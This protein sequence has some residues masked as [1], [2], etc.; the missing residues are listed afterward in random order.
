MCG[1]GWAW[2]SAGRLA[3]ER[4]LGAQRARRAEARRTR[5][6]RVVVRLARISALARK[7]HG[8]LEGRRGRPRRTKAP[9]R[10]GPGAREAGCAGAA[11]VRRAESDAVSAR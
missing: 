11:W 10:E 1:R 2:G 5:I 9:A 8:A 7:G 4:G 3:K 6:R